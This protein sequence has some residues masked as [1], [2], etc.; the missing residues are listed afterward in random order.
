[1]SY[2]FKRVKI[3][4]G[5]GPAVHSEEAIEQLM[6]AG[7]NGYRFNFSHGTHE[8]R[9][10]QVRWIRAAAEKASKPVAI[11]Q[12]LQ[13]PKIRLGEIKDNY[14]EVHAGD[15]LELTYG[16]EH[17]G[18]ILPVQY[19]LATKVQ[20][21]QQVFIFD[22]KVRTTTISVNPEQRSIKVR[23]E[24]DGF[25]MS[26]KGINLPDTDFGGDILTE[27]DLA[28]IEYAASRDYDYVAL[29]FVQRATD[30]LQLREVL[31]KF[32]SDVKVIA[33]IETKPSI[34]DEELENI[35]KVSDGV[36][37]ARGDLATEVGA[38]IVP[39]VQRKILGLCQ[40]YGK[41]SIV[42]TQ[43]MASMVDAPEPTRAEVSDI[44]TA[45]ITGAD[46]IMLSD[47]TANGK[48]PVRA[49]HTMKKVI[50]YTQEYAES[51][52]IYNHKNQH[53]D[54]C[55]KSDAISAAAA[56]LAEQL[57]V[58]AIIAETKSGAT[59]FDIAAHRPSCPIVTVTSNKRVAQQLAILYASKNFLRPDGEKAGIQLAHE[60]VESDFF[61]KSDIEVVIV[62]G[63][64]PGLIGGTDTIRV[65]KIEQ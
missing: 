37:V 55:D 17:Q 20:V 65:R 33:K 52:P 10:D 62:S 45:V 2:T 53:S 47:E 25:V 23:V 35:I 43:V 11:I 39:V 44:A 6:K 24:N 63:R 36:M 34:E 54:D 4:A 64:Q 16:A 30:I 1:M 49:V 46:A 8:E 27:K 60:L 31:A 57:G 14:Y 29:S 32:N 40:K 9:D 3:I 19:D 48:H 41:I 22:G 58:D 61:K 12:D 51:D 5:I 15:E 42:A 50:L 26:R 13:G 7:V 28:D 18:N 38:E 56:L 21:D 59:A